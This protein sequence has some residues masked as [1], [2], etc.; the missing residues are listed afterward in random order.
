MLVVRGLDQMRFKGPFQHKLFY[1]SMILL[2]FIFQ[3]FYV[4]L[5]IKM[6]NKRIALQW[7][8]PPQNSP[9]KYKNVQEHFLYLSHLDSTVCFFF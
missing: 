2:H 5:I 6:L 9:P 4:L 8:K 7:G 1:D 3:L